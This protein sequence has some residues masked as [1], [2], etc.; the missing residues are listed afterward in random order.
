MRTYTANEGRLDGLLHGFR[1][2]AARIFERH[3]MKN[4]GYWVPSDAPLAENTKIPQQCMVGLDV[5]IKEIDD[6]E[7]NER[8]RQK[9]E[10]EGEFDSGQKEQYSE[11]RNREIREL[12]QLVEINRYF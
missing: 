1:G 9:V 12:G 5:T 6:G 11:Y 8:H 3:G 2:Y 10:V 4:V 7:K